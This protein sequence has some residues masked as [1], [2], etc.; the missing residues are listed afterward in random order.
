MQKVKAVPTRVVK[1]N[2]LPYHEVLGLIQTNR[3]Q[4]QVY[5]PILS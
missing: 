4:T 5:G 2:R 1:V 3:Q